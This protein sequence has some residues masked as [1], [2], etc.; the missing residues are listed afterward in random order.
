MMRK[1]SDQDQGRKQG[2]I[3]CR[4]TDHSRPSPGPPLPFPTLPACLDHIILLLVRYHLACHLLPCP[5]SLAV[6]APVDKS[7]L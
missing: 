4:S 2:K 6:S 3:R 7:P 1:R 5:A